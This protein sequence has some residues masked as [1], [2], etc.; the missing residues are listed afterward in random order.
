MSAAS[1]QADATACPPIPWLPIP[2]KSQDGQQGSGWAAALQRVPYLRELE[3]AGATITIYRP[4]TVVQLS[5]ATGCSVS[6]LAGAYND[7]PVITLNK[8]VPRTEH[9]AAAAAAAAALSVY[10]DGFEYLQLAPTDD[11]LEMAAK[12][13]MARRPVPDAEEIFWE[14]DYWEVLRRAKRQAQE[15]KQQR[16]ERKK[17]Q[18]ERR[19][20][21]GVSNSSVSATSPNTTTT[22][23]LPS[24][25]TSPLHATPHSRQ[26]SLG[27]H[28]GDGSGGPG[29]GGDRSPAG[30]HMETAAQRTAK[31]LL[32]RA[33]FNETHNSSARLL[34]RSASLLSQGSASQST[35]RCRTRPRQD[36]I[37][38]QYT[39]LGARGFQYPI[40]SVVSEDGC[41]AMSDSLQTPPMPTMR[42]HHSREHLG[43]SLDLELSTSGG[44]TATT[45]QSARHSPDVLRPAPTAAF[46][47]SPLRAGDGGCGPAAAGSGGGQCAEAPPG[48]TSTT[49]S[50]QPA[51]SGAPAAAAEASV[52]AS[53]VEHRPR[54]ASGGVGANSL[55]P[56]QN[57]S[58]NTWVMR[59]DGHLHAPLV[60]PTLSPLA[61]AAGLQQ[62]PPSS[63]HR[64]SDPLSTAGTPP[65]QPPASLPLSLP[66]LATA[67]DVAAVRKPVEKVPPKPG[68][69]GPSTSS[70]SGGGSEHT[71]PLP[72]AQPPLPQ[73]P[74]M[75]PLSTMHR[76]ST[77]RALAGGSTA[78]TDTNPSSRCTTARPG[79]GRGGTRAPT[80]ASGTKS[81]GAASS[82]FAPSASRATVV[83]G[84]RAG[85]AAAAAAVP[86]LPEPVSVVTRAM[87]RALV[88]TSAVKS[89]TS[90]SVT[91]PSRSA[92]AA[93]AVSTPPPSASLAAPESFRRSISPP[94]GPATTI[95]ASTSSASVHPPASPVPSSTAEAVTS[96]DTPPPAV[97]ASARSSTK[98]TRKMPPPPPPQQQQQQQVQV[99]QQKAPLALPPIHISPTRDATRPAST[100]SDSTTPRG[101][102]TTVPPSLTPTREPSMSPRLE[103]TVI[104]VQ[105]A[106]PLSPEEGEAGVSKKSPTIAQTQPPSA[107]VPP[108]VALAAAAPARAAVAAS[109]EPARH[110]SLMAHGDECGA[111]G[112]VQSP[113][114]SPRTKPGD[115][116]DNLAK[117]DAAV[118]KEEQASARPS[119]AASPPHTARTPPAANSGSVA[120]PATRIS[121][122][123]AASPPPPQRPAPAPKKKA[124]SCC[125]VM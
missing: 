25:A 41:S 48:S 95:T 16:R 121:T 13:L 40:S 88:V 9:E 35:I 22:V 30:L 32:R 58:P 83:E 94:R 47:G 96:P 60:T 51:R 91:Q 39:L 82:T 57:T 64:G 69:S 79:P 43:T 85:T 3:S 116:A 111:E 10:S 59:R 18:R 72:A 67:A 66:A 8:I 26:G 4:P 23:V 14:A 77:G 120:Q 34:V 53:P 6:E 97:P 62:A 112:K 38:S 80:P 99:Q 93:A 101:T 73:R 54:D 124:T 115:V 20:L 103:R 84:E 106:A 86:R 21:L 89:V 45:T 109:E 56:S 2:A 68:S 122:T 55:A 17:A 125:T 63:L 123:P 108:V 11:S 100:P 70:P 49:S 24:T 19:T 29:T 7:L 71:A 104:A 76:R 28:Y 87:P 42:P 117:R 15:E 33:R 81:S 75:P 50:K 78:V 102:A 74:K 118:T 37:N 5:E 44:P 90:A 65:L 119:P 61:V 114:S 92:A 52:P 1:S 113:A 107:R 12:A 31:G 36:S 105:A 98:P 110:E 46:S 27:G